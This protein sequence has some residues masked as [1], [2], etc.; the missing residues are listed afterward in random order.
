MQLNYFYTVCLLLFHRA[1]SASFSYLC[2][3][4]CYLNCWFNSEGSLNRISTM[5]GL[6]RKAFACWIYCCEYEIWKNATKST[7]H[8][9]KL[10]IVDTLLRWNPQI[11]LL[12]KNKLYLKTWEFVKFSKPNAK[13]W[14]RY[15]WTRSLVTIVLLFTFLCKIVTMLCYELK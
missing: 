7:V 2:Y 15:W 1:S 13:V 8:Y 12:F 11:M 6:V 4:I 5:L 10:V 14:S 9:N 3:K